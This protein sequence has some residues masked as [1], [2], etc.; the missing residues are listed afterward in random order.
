[1][2]LA[3]NILVTLTVVV[4]MLLLERFLQLLPLLA[5]SIFRAR[6]SSSLENSVRAN[7]DRNLMAAYLSVPAL[8]VVNRYR[9]YDAA[10]LRDLP[11]P[12][13]LLAL[14]GVFAA[15]V[16]LSW[17]LFRL[18]R[19]RR[20]FDTYLRAHRASATYFIIYMLLVLGTLGLLA[21]FRLPD[22]TV[23]MVLYAE[24]AVYYLFF[25]VRRA[26]IMALSC[27]PF[28]TFLYLCGLEILPSVL[29]VVSAV[30]L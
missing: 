19:P 28:R 12:W 9:L 5:D 8:L 24:T 6:G 13:R 14:A 30:L 17:M 1:M 20:R 26:Q 21:L 10:F 11:S 16:L 3:V 4:G 29:L 23:R 2:D 27:N 15:W 25:L 22:A 18:L 7:H